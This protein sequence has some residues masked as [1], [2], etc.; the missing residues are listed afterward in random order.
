MYLRQEVIMRSLDHLGVLHPFFGITFL[1]CKQRKLPVGKM[2][3]VPIN[4]A[5]EAFLL[6]Y[7]HP[8][9]KS[10]YFFQPFKTSSRSGPWLSPKY[11]SSGSQSTRTRGQLAAAF[12]HKRDTDQWGWSPSY[13]DVLRAKL[14]QDNNGRVPAFWLAAWLFRNRAWAEDTSASNIVSVLLREF[15]INDREV[16]NLFQ[17]SIPDLPDSIWTSIPFDDALLLQ[18]LEPAPDA[19]PKEG[20]TLRVLQLSNVGPARQLDFNPAER[21]SILTGDNGLGKTFVLECAWWSLTGQWAEHSALPD[22]QR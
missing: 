3:A 6:Q 18:S 13:V 8:D 9:P 5:E 4:S 19:A 15:F 22:L 7:Y 20:G 17:V 11:P 1:V 14:D 16:E 10:R 2:I 21:L 12:L